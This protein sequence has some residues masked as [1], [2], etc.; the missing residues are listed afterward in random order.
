M[1]PTAVALLLFL[2]VHAAADDGQH[3][4]A[5]LA[6]EEAAA[7]FQVQFA[8]PPAKPYNYTTF[9]L[10][11]WPE[12]YPNCAGQPTPGLDHNEWQSP[13]D[14][15]SRK[16]Y[17]AL[18]KH[19]A[20]RFQWQ[21]KGCKGGYFFSS[22]TVWQVDL[23]DSSLSDVDC[24]NLGMTFNGTEYSLVQFH[25]HALSEHTLDFVPYAGE[26]HL[27]HASADGKLLVVGVFMEECKFKPNAFL[28]T[29]F[30]TGFVPPALLL[31][32]VIP[33]NPYKGVL[34]KGGHF[35]HYQGSLTT[36]P[37]DPGVTWL[38][39]EKPVRVRTKYMDQFRAFLKA[40]AGDSYGHNSR[41]VQALNK[42]T[43]SKTFVSALSESNSTPL[44]LPLR[45]IDK[46][47]HV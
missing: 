36:P 44:Q 42:R 32:F 30:K 17:D 12:D 1:K 29:V 35:W 10:G 6:E 19:A 34:S 47:L 26:M 33:L 20:P 3:A 13:I 45:Y 9:E 38:V 37:C 4:C 43:I 7:M 22:P 27:V 40:G 18:P 24:T 2:A 8:V 5:A 11:A 15:T 39:A 41:P 46:A 14:I 23:Q 31:D 28:E 25:F 21:D 16:A